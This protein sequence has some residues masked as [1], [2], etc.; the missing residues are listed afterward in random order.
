MCK[1][2]NHHDLVYLFLLQTLRQRRKLVREE[3]HDRWDFQHTVR[4]KFPN[5][6]EKQNQKSKP[7]LA[8]TSS[9]DTA[10]IINS[11][12]HRFYV[13]PKTVSICKAKD[14]SKDV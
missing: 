1:W 2:N 5:K 13:L 4:P 6:D 3:P 8:D 11:P 9:F 7:C 10:C 12:A 14:G